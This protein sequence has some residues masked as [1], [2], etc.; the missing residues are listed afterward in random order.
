[1]ADEDHRPILHGNCAPGDR[2]VVGQGQS[3]ILNDRDAMAVF[4]QDGVNT[5]PAR[6]IDESPMHEHDVA[7]A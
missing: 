5:L 7:N 1:M 3:R 4:R 6:A 2:H